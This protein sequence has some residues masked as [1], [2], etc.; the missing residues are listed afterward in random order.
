MIA[1][2]VHEFDGQGVHAIWL[3]FGQGG[4]QAF[5]PASDGAGEV[6]VGSS[7]GTAGQDE[8]SEVSQVGIHLI[9]FCFQAVDLGLRDSQG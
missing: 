4:D 1:E 8:R 2:A 7:G 9:D 5:G 3:D 6:Q